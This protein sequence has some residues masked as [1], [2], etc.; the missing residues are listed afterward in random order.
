MG[1]KVERKEAENFARVWN[2]NG[3]TILL[4]PEAIDFATDFSNVVLNNFIQMCQAEAAKAVEQ[5]PKII[6]EGIK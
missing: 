2:K 3:I 4:T 1:F 5:K 6:M